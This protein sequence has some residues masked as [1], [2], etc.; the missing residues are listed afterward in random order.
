MRSTFLALL[1]WSVILPYLAQAEYTPASVTERLEKHLASEDR[2]KLRDELWNDADF[3]KEIV[4]DLLKHENPAIRNEA[5]E[6]LEEFTGNDFGYV[7][8]KNP[9]IAKN[10]ESF[11]RWKDWAKGA[12]TVKK[13]SREL[14]DEDARRYLSEIM[15][16]NRE[17]F[18]RAVRRLEPYHLN[19]VGKIENFIESTPHITDGAKAKLKQAQYQLVLSRT[20]VGS[21]PTL[22]RELAFGS[23]DQK[24]AGLNSLKGA[25]LVAIPILSEFIKSEDALIRETALDA[26]LDVGGSQVLDIVGPVLKAEDDTNVIHIALRKL[27]DI[28]GADSVALVSE[29]LKHEDEDVLI[30]ALKVIKGI[31]EGGRDDPFSSGSSKEAPEND[32]NALILNLLD[33]K[34]WRVSSAALEY[35]EEAKMAQAEDK[36]VNLLSSDDDFVKASAIKAAVTLKSANAIPVLENIL[37][38]E[39]SNVG[40]VVQ[41]LVSMQGALTESQIELVESKGVEALIALIDANDDSKAPQTRLV[42]QYASHKELDVACAALRALADDRKRVAMSFVANILSDALQSGNEEKVQSVLSS[43]SMPSSSS[44][45]KGLIIGN[46]SNSAGEQF[47]NP[48]LDELYNSFAK[49]GKALN[50]Q[51]ELAATNNTGGLNGLV[52][53]LRE[54]G[55][56][57]EDMER[58]MRVTI[59]LSS[60]GDAETLQALSGRME[61]LEPSERIAVAKALRSTSSDYGLRALEILLED[62]SSEIRGYSSYAFFYSSS[63]RGLITKGLEYATKPDAKVKAWELY[64]RNL[65]YA[66][67]GDEA[68]RAVA[69][70]CRKVIKDSESR[71]DQKVLALLLLRPSFSSAD[72]ESILTLT[73]SENQLIR[74][75][76][77]HTLVSGR[78]FKIKDHQEQILGD[79]SILVR[80][81]LP[82]ALNKK[83]N[84]AW[85]HYFTEVETSQDYYYDY[86]SRNISLSSTAEKLLR[87]LADTDVSE[88]VQY[89]SLFT[90]LCYGKEIELN[91]FIDLLV[92]QP[93]SSKAEERIINFVEGNYKTMGRGLA[94]LIGY[95]DLRKIQ[96]RYR[97][98]VIRHFYGSESKAA[99]SSFGD[100]AKSVEKIEELPQFVEP[101]KVSADAPERESI[102]LVYFYE[103]GCKEC[104]RV[105]EEVFPKY[106][107][108]FKKIS[109]LELIIDKYD[110]N[111]SEGGVYNRALVSRLDVPKARGKKPAIFTQVGVVIERYYF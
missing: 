71:V 25:G 11:Q 89:E 23:R 98:A 54:L 51:R 75:A 66:A 31:S 48:K 36:V 53:A 41:G 18:Y 80:M 44:S 94:P 20:G 52:I 105:E 5:L 3:P 82:M 35:V 69:N 43:L 19:A 65:S 49:L 32:N 104:L 47:N 22:A 4:I 68:K 15:Q 26:M 46:S 90:L 72:K 55:A 59:L 99:F 87:M 96:G 50:K 84:G 67:Q 16:S 13:Q 88:Q 27:K 79:K 97:D 85:I 61:E 77:W 70:W 38:N 40:I 102:R 109:E 81:A 100:L 42:A 39:D 63:N 93:D 62:D 6:L 58:K 7:P 9:E 73:N 64:N 76:A 10:V 74:R 29:F 12:G 37:T 83:S 30:S 17:G 8:L 60:Y 34:R 21:A 14:T 106:K 111:K 56:S 1:I 107:E 91:K 78:G 45:S 108:E 103:K 95:I 33:D 28:K 92:K 101:A 110:I 24:L 86:N 2:Q 57:T